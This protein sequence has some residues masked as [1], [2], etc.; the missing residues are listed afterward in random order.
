MLGGPSIKRLITIVVVFSLLTVIG[1][2]GFTESSGALRQAEAITVGKLNTEL[3]DV[4]AYGLAYDGYPQND[5]RLVGLKTDGRTVDILAI[6]PGSFNGIHLEYKYNR[7]FFADS[8]EDCIGYVDLTKG[9]GVYEFCVLVSGVTFDRITG[10]AVAGGRLYYSYRDEIKGENYIGAVN[11]LSGKEEKELLR[12]KRMVAKEFDSPDNDLVIQSCDEENILLVRNNS[13]SLYELSSGK[14][15]VLFTGRVEPWF[16][17]NGLLIGAEYT[18][19]VYG[20]PEISGLYEYRDKQLRKLENVDVNYGRE[21]I[22]M[23]PYGQGFIYSDGESVFCY[24]DGT[25]K[26]LLS[27]K[28][29]E[30]ESVDYLVMG[31]EKTVCV[32]AFDYDDS[33]EFLVFAIELSS[34]KIKELNE[35]PVLLQAIYPQRGEGN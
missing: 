19:N 14:E 9:N 22:L 27:L 31:S 18:E 2:C 17:G 5:S 26:K 32:V 28:G 15:E 10:I 13:G 12:E 3:A 34:G 7:L 35:L 11:L 23:I 25:V 21:D 24:E 16:F 4:F 33:V 20:Y 8:E 30:F 29:R 1:G 6:Y